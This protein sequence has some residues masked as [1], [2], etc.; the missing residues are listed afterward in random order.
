MLTLVDPGPGPM[1][2]R[3]WPLLLWLSGGEGSAPK[4]LRHEQE[5]VEAG[6]DDDGELVG[7]VITPR[8]QCRFRKMGRSEKAQKRWVL[9]LALERVRFSRRTFLRNHKNLGDKSTHTHTHTQRKG[10]K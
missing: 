6:F 7:L 4:K 1:E 8:S 10:R 9:I 5:D 2:D 3:K